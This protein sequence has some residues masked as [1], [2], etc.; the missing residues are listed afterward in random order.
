MN[1]VVVG[2]RCDSLRSHCGIGRLHSTSGPKDQVLWSNGNDTC[3]TNRKRWF[4]SIQDYLP[5]TNVKDIHSN[6]A[7]AVNDEKAELRPMYDAPRHSQ[8]IAMHNGI[9]PTTLRAA[10]A[11]F[12]AE[13]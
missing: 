8:W 7:E 6:S 3:L 9:H 4:D 10:W 12:E 1:C 5:K 11:S 13:R 2:E